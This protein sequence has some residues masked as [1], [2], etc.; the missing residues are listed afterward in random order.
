M[1]LELEELAMVWI[2]G[3]GVLPTAVPQTKG[4]FT[5]TSS[6][7]LRR[8]RDAAPTHDETEVTK[9]DRHPHFYSPG[10]LFRVEGVCVLVILK[11]KSIET[12]EV[13]SEISQ[14]SFVSVVLPLYFDIVSHKLI[15]CREMN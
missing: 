1:V 6:H 4:F 7:F 2:C 11:K 15:N 9:R 3:A 10:H 13:S 14:L 12:Y 5:W 8:E